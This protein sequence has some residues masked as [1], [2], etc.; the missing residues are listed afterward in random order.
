[1]AERWDAVSQADGTYRLS[2][3]GGSLDSQLLS[4]CS[5]QDEVIEQVLSAHGLFRATR[6]LQATL[7]M[8]DELT[9]ALV[10]LLPSFVF[11]APSPAEDGLWS[12]DAQADGSI[13]FR[14]GSMSIPPPDPVMFMP[15]DAIPDDHFG[16]GP[17]FTATT[18]NL[19][20]P[21]RLFDALGGVSPTVIVHD[22][23]QG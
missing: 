20:M 14:C 11:H 16:R 5:D 21:D 1:M 13:V 9:T 23:L 15:T 8:P 12:V 19:V 18:V 6:Q 4:V 2:G 3:P 10:D 17:G 7:L 22:P